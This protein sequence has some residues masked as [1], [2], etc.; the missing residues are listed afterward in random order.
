MASNSVK[1][2]YRAL[3]KARAD[4][5]R[6]EVE[7]SRIPDFT[8]QCAASESASDNVRVSYMHDTGNIAITVREEGRNNVCHLGPLATEKLRKYLEVVTS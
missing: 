7:L 3:E 1:A 2:Q 8:A 6:L 5:E 4:V